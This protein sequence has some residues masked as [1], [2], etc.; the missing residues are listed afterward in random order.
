MV[1]PRPHFVQKH[2]NVCVQRSVPYGFIVLVMFGLGCDYGLVYVVAQRKYSS[3]VLQSV[4]FPSWF[5][6][7]MSEESIDSVHQYLFS[8]VLEI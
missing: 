8:C 1:V 5:Y 7:L 3:I 2:S 6:G 4:H